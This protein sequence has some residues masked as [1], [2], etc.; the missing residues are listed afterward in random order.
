M[1]IKN[2]LNIKTNSEK[3][4]NFKKPF[5]V[6]KKIGI[7]NKLNAGKIIIT[8][9]FDQDKKCNLLLKIAKTKAISKTMLRLILKRLSVLN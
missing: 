6:L 1:L 8:T 9:V 7:K 3:I 5:I 4:P 2:K